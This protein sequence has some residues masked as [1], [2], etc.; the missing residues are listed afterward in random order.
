MDDNCSTMTDNCN[1]CSRMTTAIAAT[2]WMIT[3]PAAALDVV[4]D[5]HDL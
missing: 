2:Q 3:A 4:S 1:G 5:D